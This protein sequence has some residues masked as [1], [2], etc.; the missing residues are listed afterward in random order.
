LS[1]ITTSG[2]EN[3][4]NSLSFVTKLLYAAPNLAARATA[5]PSLI[6]LPKFYRR[7]GGS[8]VGSLAVEILVTRCLDAIIGPAIGLISDRTQSRWAAAV[9]TWGRTRDAVIRPNSFD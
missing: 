6:T 7:R 1:G 8:A 2:T 3:T 4:V 9:P 5:I